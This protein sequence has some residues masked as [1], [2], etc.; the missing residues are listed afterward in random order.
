MSTFLD[1]GSM[2][3]LMAH[4]GQRRQS[5][6]AR[7]VEVRSL[8]LAAIPGSGLVPIWHLTR[9]LR[10]VATFVEVSVAIHGLKEDGVIAG[11]AAGYRRT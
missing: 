11:N 9:D 2:A 5:R 10:P 1:P 7:A 6:E 4:S 8:V 3:I